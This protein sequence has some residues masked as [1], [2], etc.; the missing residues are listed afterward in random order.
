MN[1]HIKQSSPLYQALFNFVIPIVILTKYSGASSL[2]PVTALLTA[3]TF[4][5]VFE[6][7]SIYVRHKLSVVSIFS[8]GGIIVTGAISLLGLSEGW[9]ALRRSL[10]YF[11]VSLALLIAIAFQYPL[12]DKILGQLLLLDKAKAAALKRKN[13]KAMEAAIKNTG[14]SIVILFLLIGISSYIL[15]RI[16]IN[17]PAKTEAFN[18]QYAEL[19]ILALACT[20]LPIFVGLTAIFVKL[21]LKIEKLTSLKTTSFMK[22]THES[23][24]AKKP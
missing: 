23:K 22:S 1:K 18:K 8:I 24:L 14:I 9:L 16:I 10:P 20:T 21:V 13:D 7:H 11:V 17:A 6:L 3:L 19:R 5:V 12:I 4:P 2:G 15:T